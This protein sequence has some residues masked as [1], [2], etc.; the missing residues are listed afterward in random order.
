MSLWK[1]PDHSA[2]AQRWGDRGGGGS[3]ALDFVVARRLRKAQIIF[4]WTVM[5]KRVQILMSA[6]NWEV[7]RG[8][9]H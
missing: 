2:A 8:E 5:V 4:V 6:L 7:P 9:G 3:Y 1:P